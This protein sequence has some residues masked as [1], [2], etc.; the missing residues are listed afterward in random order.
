[1]YVNLK[2][3]KIKKYWLG[4]DLQLEQKK[5]VDC[6]ATENGSQWEGPDTTDRGVCAE[7]KGR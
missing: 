4:N 7:K 2:Q 1:M 5:Y 3:R 6:D